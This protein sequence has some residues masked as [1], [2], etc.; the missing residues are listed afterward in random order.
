MCSSDLGII[1]SWFGRGGGLVPFGITIKVKSCKEGKSFG[2]GSH[3]S[4][5]IEPD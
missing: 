4:E 1:P 3:S 5:I 2:V